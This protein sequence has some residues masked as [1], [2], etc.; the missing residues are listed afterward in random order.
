VGRG[1]LVE[2]SDP[3]RFLAVLRRTVEVLDAW[4]GPY[5]LFGTIGKSVYAEDEPAEDVDVFLREDDVD[6]ALDALLRAGFE[7]GEDEEEGWLRKAVAD[8]VL[9]DLIVRVRMGVRFDDDTAEHVRRVSYRGIDLPVPSPEDLVVI[10]ACS[11]HP[12]TPDHW[13]IARE[14]V[15]KAELDWQRLVDRGRRLAPL[16]VASLLLYCESD[17]VAVPEGTVAALL[18]S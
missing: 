18:E 9:V 1:E 3:E 10:N 2:A 7:R 14:L 5:A 12:D 8:G 16:R 17:E 15:S 13:F 4:G 6:G 11:A